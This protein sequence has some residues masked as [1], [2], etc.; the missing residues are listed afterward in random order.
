MLADI[1]REMTA[2]DFASIVLSIIATI[3]S[4]LSLSLS[5]RQLVNTTITNNRIEWINSVRK[6]VHE[7]IAIYID[8]NTD[9]VLKK[10]SLSANIKLYVRDDAVFYGNFIYVLEKCTANSFNELDY[11]NLIRATQDMLAD[12]WNRMK[13][14]AG[15][16]QYSERRLRKRLMIEKQEQERI[17]K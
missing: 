2:L 5:K 15:I 6:L 16:S 11:N 9:N 1:L 7:F 4:I 10:K 13:R 17:R 3:V 12:V 8:D 14:E